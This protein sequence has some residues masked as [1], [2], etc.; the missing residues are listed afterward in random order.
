MLRLSSSP[1]GSAVA[2]LSRPAASLTTAELTVLLNQCRH[3]DGELT[4]DYQ[5]PAAAL[6]SALAQQHSQQLSAAHLQIVLSSCMQRRQ[7]AEAVRIFASSVP[8]AYLPPPPFPRPPA[9]SH[10]SSSLIPDIS[11]YNRVL[12]VLLAE[13]AESLPGSPSHEQVVEAHAVPLSLAGWLMSSPLFPLSS[14]PLAFDVFTYVHLV[15][16][17]S[18][19]R[20]Q[21]KLSDV[22]NRLDAQ[23]L[24]P[25]AALCSLIAVALHQAG[26][27]QQVLHWFSLALQAEQAAATRF[28][29]QFSGEA[30]LPSPSRCYNIAI[31]AAVELGLY[32]QAVSFHRDMQRK[33]LKPD[34]ATAPRIA[35][36]QQKM[37][38][39]TQQRP[40]REAEENDIKPQQAKTAA[41]RRSEA[42]SEQQQEDGRSG[43]ADNRGRSRA[44][45][46]RPAHKLAPSDLSALSI[47][48]LLSK[49]QHQPAVALRR[50]LS[51]DPASLSAEDVN[52][53]FRFCSRQR[54][55]GIAPAAKFLSHLLQCQ[56]PLVITQHLNRVLG[57]C[58]RKGEET[59]MLRIF[60]S[61]VPAAYVPPPPF[62]SPPSVPAFTLTPDMDSYN[63]LLQL[64][65]K[66][67]TKSGRSFSALSKEELVAAYAAPLSLANW[68]MSSPLFPVEPASSSP[69]AFT[70]HTYSELATLYASCQ[71]RS[72]LHALISRLQAQQLQPDFILCCSL[73]SALFKT[74]DWKEAVYWF[75]QGL[76]LEAAAASAPG[77]GAESAPAAAAPPS[78]ITTKSFRMAII[79]A[80]Q[81]G[82]YEEAVSFHRVM[83]SRGVPDAQ[84]E[85]DGH[86]RQQLVVAYRR[87]GQEDMAQQLE[88]GGETKGQ[89]SQQSRPDSKRPLHQA[90]Q[91]SQRRDTAAEDKQQPLQQE[92]SSTSR[93]SPSR[94]SAKVTSSAIA[95]V[96]SSSSPS[97]LASFPASASTPSASPSAVAVSSVTDLLARLRKQ[98]HDMQHLQRVL[99]LDPSSLSAAELD[100]LFH[101]CQFRQLLG[102]A[103][104]FL[105]SLVQ[106]QSP[107]LTA[108]HLNRVLAIC[109]ARKDWQ[110]GLEIFSRS[111]PAEYLPP[112]PFP[113]PQLFSNSTLRPDVESYNRLLQLLLEQAQESA[114]SDSQ[115]VAARREAHAGALSLAAWLMSSPL[116]PETPSLPPSPLAFDSH[117]YGYLLSLYSRCRLETQLPALIKRLEVQQLQPDAF[118][119]CTIARALHQAG[120]FEEVL[121]WFSRALTATTVQ[122]AAED[123]APGRAAAAATASS[124]SASAIHS[125]SF[126]IAIDAASRL[127]RGAQAIAWHREMQR[128]GLQPDG[129]VVY[130]HLIKA[131]RQRGELDV[132]ES[133]QQEAERRGM[134]SRRDGGA[135]RASRSP[136][137]PRASRHQRDEDSA[138]SDSAVS[139]LLPQADLSSLPFLDLVY[140]LPQQPDVVLPALLHLSQQP[141]AVT[142]ADLTKLFL[143]CLRHGLLAP[144]V[145]VLLSLVSS[146]SPQLNVF[147]LQVVL[148]ICDQ[149]K[150][151]AEGLRVLRFSVAEA[152]LPHPPFP[153]ESAPSSSRLIPSAECY[154][155][156]LR[157]LIKQATESSQPESQEEAKEAYAAPLSLARW[158]MSSP[159][160]PV[161][162]SPSSSSVALSSDLYR[163]LIW[164]FARCDLTD[165]LMAV[166]QRLE[167][168]LQLQP[169]AGLCYCLWNALCHAGRIQPA[170]A[171]FLQALELQADDVQ[172][173]DCSAAIDFAVR[174]HRLQDAVYIHSQMQRRG[175]E[176]DTSLTY[177]QLA[178]AYRR[179]GQQDRAQELEQE[180]EW[181]GMLR[182]GVESAEQ[183][184]EA[185]AG[186]EEAAPGPPL[187]SRRSPFS[188]SPSLFVLF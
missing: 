67:A 111:V 71:L 13:A 73:S 161:T 41:P 83:Q 188:S 14:S 62:P 108:Q 23:Q 51:L 125:R 36:A 174:R 100:L 119:C 122:A 127:S 151:W 46:S 121:H 86:S 162:A 57:L 94:D 40:Q 66:A 157:F 28:F 99:S 35:L 10:S 77:S 163:H 134:T 135:D 117:T 103:V 44:T 155:H 37:A 182:H 55:K 89:Q 5:N 160:F 69:L 181:K 78:R 102:L 168:S 29:N 175:L 90:Q 180:A 72:E 144:A 101:T 185:D 22:L 143:A 43:R 184:E 84:H 26:R 60:S 82:Q 128:R 154:N 2:L 32:E 126:S 3:A 98:P 123:A 149:Q 19:C 177:A 54:H 138:P 124:T 131:Y 104:E 52:S 91:A 45:L 11:C 171:W 109:C 146:Q 115:S 31:E 74:E 113:R 156:A 7:R 169:D 120:R 75:S 8:S 6:L 147:H 27:W 76:A 70:P 112:P 145:N 16:L 81:V 30:S 18:R 42:D 93:R 114:V 105:S 141:D 137:H 79:A 61:S 139:P 48:D 96:P 12:R 65:M 132:A 25:N 140:H 142:P 49:L 50:L 166:V 24:Q 130:S 150:E 9:S 58:R 179:L 158:L 34:K 68:L 53:F 4:T 92:R 172:V 88:R 173:R 21:A 95:S 56:S 63:C 20:L 187:E 167:A 165:E 118:I 17:L 178:W 107:L 186:D 164:L 85:L 133:L 116:F 106:R 183:L 110:K 33:R 153:T 176:V 129:D 47:A 80:V 148:S 152:Y 59:E 87:L 159:L 15:T 39:A 136:S 38:E 170:L 64:M 1:D 97:P